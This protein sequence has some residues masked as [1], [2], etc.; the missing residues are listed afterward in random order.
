VSPENVYTDLS[1]PSDEKILALAAHV[2]IRL[3][4]A[5]GDR[6]HLEAIE[7]SERLVEERVD[8]YKAL[9][10]DNL[11]LDEPLWISDRLDKRHQF[12]RRVED[13]RRLERRTTQGA[14]K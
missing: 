7:E 12:I 6:L 1:T 11:K 9:R 4:L 3:T 5:D 14:V 8:T 10:I 2:P 13:N